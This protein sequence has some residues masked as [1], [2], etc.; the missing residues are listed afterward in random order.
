[1]SKLYQVSVEYLQELE[2]L[3]PEIMSAHESK[4]L[5][6]RQKT[7]WRRVQEIFKSIRW[8]DG[9]NTVYKVENIEESN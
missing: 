5:S 6:N 1:M 8:N 9:P 3:L 2:I 7:Q 4:I